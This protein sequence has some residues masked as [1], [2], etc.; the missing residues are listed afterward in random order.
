MFVLGPLLGGCLAG[1]FKRFDDIQVDKIKAD[2]HTLADLTIV[3]DEF[4][5]VSPSDI[6]ESNA[7]F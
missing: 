5:D 7:R 2:A 3:E 6:N 1:F 4:V